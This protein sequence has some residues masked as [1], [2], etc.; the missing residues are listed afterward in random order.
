MASYASLDN[1]SFP[2]LSLGSLPDLVREFF[3]LRSWIGGQMTLLFY[4]TSLVVSVIFYIG[5]IVMFSTS[6][7]WFGAVGAVVFGFLHLVI[8]WI[9]LRVVVELFL[10]VFAIRAALQSH[11]GPGTSVAV[12]DTPITVDNTTA[13]HVAYQSESFA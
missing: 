2:Y 1:D 4:Y 7:G 9:I 6:S 3:L 5:R 12:H 10:S 8:T 13:K 11:H